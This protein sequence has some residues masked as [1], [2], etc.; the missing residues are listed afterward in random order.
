MNLSLNLRGCFIRVI[1]QCGGDNCRAHLVC[2]FLQQSRWPLFSGLPVQNPSILLFPF[3][4]PRD[5]P[6]SL[7]LPPPDRSSV[8]VLVCAV[9]WKLSCSFKAGMLRDWQR[10][11]SHPGC[12]NTFQ[13]PHTVYFAVR[14][15][16]PLSLFF[17][18]ASSA[19]PSLPSLAFVFSFVVHCWDV[20]SLVYRNIQSQR[21]LLI[22]CIFAIIYSLFIL[23]ESLFG[24]DIPLALWQIL[25]YNFAGQVR[26]GF[27]I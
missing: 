9:W 17:L 1:I 3:F 15:R 21:H 2:S 26:W 25:F 13:S 5:W 7:L 14:I 11:F 20:L 18:F 10:T 19:R 4:P 27:R 16:L 23:L 6:C 12:W 24:I 8:P 22:C